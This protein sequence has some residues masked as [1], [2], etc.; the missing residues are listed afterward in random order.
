MIR[1]PK[2]DLLVPSSLEEAMQYISYTNSD[3]KILAGGTDLL[4][5]LKKELFRPKRMVWLG[6]IKEL[7]NIKFSE[8]EGLQIGAMCTLDEIERNQDVQHYF[9]S[10]VHA[11]RSIASPQ[12]RNR[13]T[14]GGNLCLDTRCMYYDQSEFWRNSLGYCLKNGSGV[15]HAAPGLSSCTAV[16]CSDLAPLLIALDS[17]VELQSSALQRTISLS[18]FYTND[19]VHPLALGS[20]EVLSKI[21]ILYN[22]LAKSIH[23]KLRSRSSID[24]PLVNIGV[25]LTFSNSNICTRARIVVGAV[26]S[27]PFVN[28]SVLQKLVG[29]EITKELI[30]EIAEDISIK[31]HPMPNVDGSVNYR[32]RMVRHLIE[33]NLINMMETK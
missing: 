20:S 33:Y 25:A 32:K 8:R 9:P 15:C 12:I 28:D 21:N 4:V 1:L 6:K 3:I 30:E 5:G 31:I 11:V 26:T 10:L 19:G 29:K 23:A 16:F 22:P 18:E 14:I 7:K 13:A 17:T 27:S 24:F 2:F